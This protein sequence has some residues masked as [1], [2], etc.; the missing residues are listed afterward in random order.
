MS[1]PVNGRVVII[2]DNPD[3]GVPLLRALSQYRVSATYFTG[4]LEELPENPFSDVRLVFLDIELATRGADDKTKISKCVKV[5]ER[6]VSKDNGPFIL[7]LWTKYKPLIKDLI[8]KLKKEDY[9]LIHFD[10]KKSEVGDMED[11]TYKYYIEKIQGK[12]K[13]TLKKFG[14]FSLLIKWENLIHDS[15]SSVTNEFSMLVGFN[16]ERWNDELTNVFSRM[17][18]AWA[19]KTLD[20]SNQGEIKRNAL[21]TFNGMLD[22]VVEKTISIGKLED[23]NLSFSDDVIE[24]GIIG[25]INTKLL[26]DTS[27]RNFSPGNIYR[28]NYNNHFRKLIYDSIDWKMLHPEFCEIIDEDLEEVLDERKRIK[29]EYKRNWSDFKQKLKGGLKSKVK[30]VL[31]EVSP[32]CDFAQKKMVL[33]RLVKGYLCPI[34]IKLDDGKTI[35]MYKKLKRNAQFIF[36]TPIFEYESAP[37]KLVIDLRYFTSISMADMERR[38]PLFRIRKELLTVIQ[39]KLSSHI[40]RSGLLFLE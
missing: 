20:K 13:K 4:N 39:S 1:L 24:P 17:A 11:D 21:F 32:E 14:V 30:C 27:I 40:N 19:G 28:K 8:K 18:E 10:L 22:D 16:D 6:V 5:V 3:E 25:K 29:E 38:K 31:L 9:K 23:I 12:L 7:L 2:D 33:S 35:E 36:I 26:L 34:K 37:Y 15:S